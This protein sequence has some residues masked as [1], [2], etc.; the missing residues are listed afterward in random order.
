MKAPIMYFKADPTDYCRITVGGKIKAE[1]KG[2]SKLIWPFKTTIEMINTSLMNQPYS[3]PEVT[4]DNQQVT[5]Q[6]SFLYCAKEPEKVLNHF[7]CAINPRN[8]NNKKG[9]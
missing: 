6:G 9:F 2:V 7:N 4:S 8:K 5:V 3:F 1:E